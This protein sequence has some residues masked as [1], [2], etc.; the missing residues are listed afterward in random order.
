[1]APLALFGQFDNSITNANWKEYKDSKGQ[2]GATLST[3]NG[4]PKA[5]LV[6][7]NEK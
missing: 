7:W 3:D 4:S 5:A 6:D 1:M 2:E